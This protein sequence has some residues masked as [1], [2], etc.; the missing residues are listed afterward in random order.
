MKAPFIGRAMS[1]LVMLGLVAWWGVRVSSGKP[2][3]PKGAFPA[4]A[5]DEQPAAKSGKEKAVFAGGCF[6]GV[7]GVFQ[8]LKGVKSVTSG[9]SGGTVDHPYYELVSSGS[10]GHAESVEVEYDPSQITYGKLLMIFFSVAHDPTQKDRQGPD[11]G[12]QYRSAIFYQTPEQKRIAEAYIAQINAA[13]VYERPIATQV[14]A[15]QAFYPA[16]DYHQNYMEQHPDNPYIR[17]NDLPKVER[18]RKV[19]PE[20]YK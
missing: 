20:M 2:A 4:P 19:Y 3:E 11:I 9:Y 18:L 7:Q 17:Y 5:T 14:A 6:W 1:I 15:Y 12:T 13:G 10:T 16:E 8:H